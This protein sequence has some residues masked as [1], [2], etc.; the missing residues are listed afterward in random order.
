MAS[1][2]DGWVTISPG[3]GSVRPAATPAI[4][5][6]EDGWVTVT[7]GGTEAPPPPDKYRQAAQAQYDRFRK[8]G[9]SMTTPGLTDR[10]AQ[11][12]SLGFKDEILAGLTTPLEMITHR[13]VDPRE[14]YRY[15]KAYQDLANEEA[16]KVNPYYLGTAMDVLGG[17][18]TMG[19]AGAGRGIAANAGIG[20]VAGA[21]GGAGEAK[22][23]EDIPADAAKGGVMGGVLGVAAPAVG[24]L[25]SRGYR[26]LA[27]RGW[28]GGI[29]GIVARQATIN[30]QQVRDVANTP[31]AM[32]A[33]APNMLPVAQGAATGVGGP[34][35]ADLVAALEAR[36]RGTAQRIG[37]DLDQTVG[38][39]P[40]PSHVDRAISEQ[41][42]A[43]GPAYEQVLANARAID[44]RPLA[45][46]LDVLIVNERGPAQAAARRA[47]RMIDLEGSPGV[48][49]PHPRAT[50]AA[51][52]AVRGMA[53][54]ATDPNVRRVLRQAEAEMTR[55]LQAK[56]PGIRQLDSQY[57]ELGAQQRAIR[58]GSA[59]TDIFATG[60]NT[61]YRPA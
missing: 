26:A 47:R 61:A 41:M 48:L 39:A 54:D 28:F 56:V 16:N 40:V 13:T 33:D 4:V 14:G 43:L 58:A 38:P 59:G 29:P 44:N 45:Q 17:A 46:A 35:R 8:A 19:T 60:Q 49:D 30:P 12:A 52:T 20:T 53:E 22:S 36:N 15:A 55:E 25:A 21:V 9:G 18:R 7:P 57:A 34:G 37:S 32:I 10:Y 6:T 27:D 11:G 5:P 51:R 23:L 50:Q 31:G 1:D 42:T 2:D 3:H 24:T